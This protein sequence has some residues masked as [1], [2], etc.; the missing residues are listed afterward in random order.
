MPDEDV[1]QLADAWK[2]AYNDL[3]EASQPPVASAKDW[4]AKRDAYTAAERAYYRLLRDRF[5]WDPPV[6]VVLDDG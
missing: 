6:S 1:K 5:G 4:E 3:W 2:A